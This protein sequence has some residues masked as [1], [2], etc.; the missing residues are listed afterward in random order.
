MREALDE[1]LPKCDRLIGPY[2]EMHLTNE[3]YHVPCREH[4][5]CYVI[6]IDQHPETKAIVEKIIQAK[7]MRKS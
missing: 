3:P 2:E 1:D 4:G 7:K 6:C 5:Q